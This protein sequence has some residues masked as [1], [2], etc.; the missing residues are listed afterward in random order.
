MRADYL[1]Y[2]ISPALQAEVGKVV[3]TPLMLIANKQ[4]QFAQHLQ[5]YQKMDSLIPVLG[6]AG[7]ACI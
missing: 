2:E 3:G 5:G 1:G 6:K 7:L 4:G